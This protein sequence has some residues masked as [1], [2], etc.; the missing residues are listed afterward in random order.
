M[1]LSRRSR[2]L[3]ALLALICVLFAQIAVAGF[4]CPSMQIGHAMASIAAPAASSADH[5]EM[6]GCMDMDMEQTPACHHDG[7]SR[8]QSLDKPAA[9]DVQPFVAST[10]MLA[11]STVD[12]AALASVLP[13]AQRVPTRAT[14]PPLTIQNCC[15]RI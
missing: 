8:M 9:P 13:V 10:M 4:A 5:Q 14:S 6:V 7:Q 12:P 1:R 11:I 3:S 2:C 15:F